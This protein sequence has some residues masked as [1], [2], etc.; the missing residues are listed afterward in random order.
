MDASSVGLATLRLIVLAVM[1]FGLFGLIIP[2]LPGLVI[3]WVPA[4]VYGLITGFNLTSGILFAVM[5]VLMLIGNVVDNFVMG[6][7]ARQQGA[8]WVAIGVAIALGLLGS[9]VAPPFGGLIAALVGLFAVEYYRLR[10]LQKAVESTRSMAIG[11][12]WAA[13]I[14]FGIGIVMILLWGAWVLWA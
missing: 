8:S 11:C 12:G 6:A 9:I 3:I 2:V 7:S 10:D 1:L 14:R 13:L 4:L 5:T